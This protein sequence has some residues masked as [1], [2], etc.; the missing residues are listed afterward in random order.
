ML[1][2]QRRQYVRNAHTP[3]RTWIRKHARAPTLVPRN[4]LRGRKEG[5]QKNGPVYHCHATRC[6]DMK[7]EIIRLYFLRCLLGCRETAHL[8]RERELLSS[9]FS[10][11]RCM[12]DNDRKLVALTCTFL[13]RPVG[14]INHASAMNIFLF[15]ISF[16]SFSP[17]LAFRFEFFNI[18][19]CSLVRRI[20]RF[21][22]SYSCNF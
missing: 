13:H 2:R 1:R 20:F 15:D 8:L 16:L 21:F 5:F 10:R 17:L 9:A 6:S 3:T 18:I 4:R 19:V 14:K 12:R 22:L 11:N 7:K